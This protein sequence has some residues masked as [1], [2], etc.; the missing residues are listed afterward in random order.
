MRT[1]LM[2]LIISLLV[3]SNSAW[4]AE[5]H[6]FL[7][8]G[9][10][11]TGANG[12]R[13]GDIKLRDEH[14]GWNI[15]EGIPVNPPPF[16]DR[17]PTVAIIDS[18]I[19]ADHPQVKGLIAEQQDFTGEGSE[20]RIGHGT[21]VTIIYVGEYL[22]E[23]ES[24]PRI[25]V[26]KVANADGTID[27]NAVISA[28][29]WAAQ[30]GAKVVNISLGFR[31][32]TGDYSDL[33]YVIAN[34][35][36]IIFFAAA[37]NFGPNVKVYP[38]ACSSDNLVSVGTT[39]DWSGIGDIVVPSG[40]G[41]FRFVP[42]S[43][44]IVNTSADLRNN[45]RTFA[46]LSS[47]TSLATLYRLGV[48][49]D[50]KLVQLDC[51]PQYEIKTS[52]MIGY[53]L[54]PIV[55]PKDKLNPTRGMWKIRYQL[56][57]CG[58]SKIY[59]ALFTAN[60]NGEAPTASADFPGSTNANRVQVKNAMKNNIPLMLILSGL[61]DCKDVDVFDMRVTTPAH[62]LVPGKIKGVWN[63]IWTLKACGQMIDVAMTFIPYPTNPSKIRIYSNLVKEGEVPQ[64]NTVNH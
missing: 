19:L 46:Y 7:L 42:F 15:L 22:A 39:D 30:H 29:Q 5:R 43:D 28:I 64:P 13:E 26:A 8:G 3:L 2:M 55:F 58:E 50:R 23:S 60:S 33:C 14:G 47:S 54:D 49:Q 45:K 61:K 56:E 63:E 52:T 6:G 24:G 12:P 9:P 32:G 57:R 10:A 44:E 16:T 41:V 27:K 36:D 59:N 53:V 38:A 34:H 18:G 31:E 37:G 4:A 62:D 40:T 35:R 20:D 11:G 21:W 17:D 25:I 1:K 51:E 48:E